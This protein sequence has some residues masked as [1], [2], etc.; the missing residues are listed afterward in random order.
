[1]INIH[2]GDHDRKCCQISYFI[3]SGSFNARYPGCPMVVS[4][5]ETVS[6]IVPRSSQVRDPPCDATSLCEYLHAVHGG[7]RNSRIRRQVYTIL[8]PP[9]TLLLEMHSLIGSPAIR[10]SSYQIN[11]SPRRTAGCSLRPR[12]RSS[13][14]SVEPD[15]HDWSSCMNSRQVFPVSTVQL[16]KIHRQIHFHRPVAPQL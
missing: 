9:L 8:G 2:A 7:E 5:E 4:S 11:F 16:P 10:R 13:R 15:E 12:S 14:H 1:M 6:Y 3:F